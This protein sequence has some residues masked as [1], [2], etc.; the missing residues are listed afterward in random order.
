MVYPDGGTLTIEGTVS[1]YGLSRS[2]PLRIGDNAYTNTAI[3][4][5][6]AKLIINGTLEL[7]AGR[8]LYYSANGQVIVNASGTLKITYGDWGGIMFNY[9]LQQPADG[10]LR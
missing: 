9:A 8:D 1:V 2:T 3:S 4:R 10:S 7:L 5:R 6:S